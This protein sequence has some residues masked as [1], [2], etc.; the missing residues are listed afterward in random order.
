[1][2]IIK[3]PSQIR[4]EQAQGLISLLNDIKSSI[5]EDKVNLKNCILQLNGVL[6]RYYTLQDTQL[7]TADKLKKVYSHLRA[8]KM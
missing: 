4:E 7:S 2:A 1:M 8:Q 3:S 5:D 6:G